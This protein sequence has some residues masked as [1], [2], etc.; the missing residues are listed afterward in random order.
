MIYDQKNIANICSTVGTGYRFSPNTLHVVLRAALESFGESLR[1]DLK[2]EDKR[3]TDIHLGKFEDG[4]P[5]ENRRIPLT[6]ITLALAFLVLVSTNT[7]IDS[8]CITPSE[9]CY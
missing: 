9:Y 3:V 1:N 7:S 5:A 4:E 2:N 6:D 8:I